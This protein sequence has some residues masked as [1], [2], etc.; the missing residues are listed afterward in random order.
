M[1]IIQIILLLAVSLRKE[2]YSGA[3]SNKSKVIL[4][5]T[6][7]VYGFMKFDPDTIC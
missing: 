6:F 2:K 4:S 1:G 7:K 5:V 3:A